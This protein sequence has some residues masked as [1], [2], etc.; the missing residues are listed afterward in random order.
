MS[1]KASITIIIIGPDQIKFNLCCARIQ[2]MKKI[3]VSYCF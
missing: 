1:S 2:F 3:S